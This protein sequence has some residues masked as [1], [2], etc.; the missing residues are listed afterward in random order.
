MAKRAN[1][2]GTWEVAGASHALNVSEPD[3]VVA[4]VL[5]AVSAVSAI[6]TAASA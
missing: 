6:E 1:A 4:S 5:E 2:K 3:A